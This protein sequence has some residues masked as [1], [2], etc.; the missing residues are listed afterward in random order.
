MS[1]ISGGVQY[2]LPVDEDGAIAI[3]TDN[4]YGLSN[5]GDVIYYSMLTGG[6]PWQY[7]I[8]DNF[9]GYPPI[10]FQELRNLAATRNFTLST[11]QNVDRAINLFYEVLF[12]LYPPQGRSDANKRRAK[13]IVRRKQWLTD[14]RSGCGDNV[15]STRFLTVYTSLTFRVLS[16]FPCLFEWPAHVCILGMS[17]FPLCWC[18]E[19]RPLIPKGLHPD[20]VAYMTGGNCR[21]PVYATGLLDGG[22]FA[23]WAC[24]LALL[25]QVCL[26]ERH[27]VLPLRSKLSHVTFGQSML[28]VNRIE[29]SIPSASSTRSVA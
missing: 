2:S 5:V 6:N 28:E 26:P 23:R 18:K 3:S 8:C 20:I 22:Q 10:S 27:T 24:F 4:T 7:W 16:T 19:L 15:A 17:P 29:F 9:Q 14:M 1:Y 25:E 12:I 13:L 21:G 11:W